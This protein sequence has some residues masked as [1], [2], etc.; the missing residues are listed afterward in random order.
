LGS[1]IRK[2]L[3]QV[4]SAIRDIFLHIDFHHAA[5]IIHKG[6]GTPI[7]C[8]FLRLHGKNGFVTATKL[9]K[10]NEFLLL[11]PNILP[12]Q[13]NVLLIEPNILLL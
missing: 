10:T 13:P 7:I 1:I 5:Y 9:G 12:Q 3:A 8:N 11:Q 4:F 6:T 2:I